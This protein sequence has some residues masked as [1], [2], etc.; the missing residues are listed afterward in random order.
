MSMASC[1]MSLPNYILVIANFF[2]SGPQSL[3]RC[4]PAATTIRAALLARICYSHMHCSTFG[5]ISLEPQ[6]SKAVLPR[7]IPSCS[8]LF[9][10]KP[11]L[12]AVTC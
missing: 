12:V 10:G 1:M 8:V 9:F 5:A 2:S 4:R 11:R 3:A 7:F 6:R